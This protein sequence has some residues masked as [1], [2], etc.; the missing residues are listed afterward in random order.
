MSAPVWTH[1]SVG[2]GFLIFGVLHRVTALSDALVTVARADGEPIPF[3]GA[4][5]T[6]DRALFSPRTKMNG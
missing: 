4:T 3:H 1:L 6:Y 2:Q 5:R